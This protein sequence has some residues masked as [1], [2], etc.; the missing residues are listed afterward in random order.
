MLERLALMEAGWRYG[1]PMADALD[2]K[3]RAPDTKAKVSVARCTDYWYVA[4][5]SKD[6][7]SEPQAVTI[8]GIPMVLFRAEDGTPGALLDRCPHRNVPLSM[9]EVD[10]QIL[11]CAYHGWEF[12][13]GGKC[14][15]IPGL[16]TDSDS[17]GRDATSYPVREQQGYVWVFTNADKAPEVEPFDIPLLRDERYTHVRQLVE[18]PGTLHATIENALDVPHTAFLH[19]GLFRGKGERNDIQ[20]VIRR[21]SDRVEAQYIGEPRPEGL[22][23]RVA[24]PGGGEVEHYDRFFLPSVA[25]VEYKIGDDSHILVTSM[26]TPVED[27]HTKLFTVI[28][29]RFSKMPGWLVRPI[30]EPI[31]KKIFKQDAVML[32]K[33]TELIARFGG[34]QFVSTEIDLLGPQIWRLMKAAERGDA[35]PN[36]DDPV[37]KHVEMNV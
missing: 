1:A 22:A 6:L 36:E 8:L 35:A 14:K 7:R 15:L 19:K 17:D 20:V 12:G 5:A 34:E 24:S 21:W 9:G 10:G 4:C 18:A 28:S 2:P 30:L 31:G 27:F 29:F 37:V 33:Q 32:G 11:R 26:C 3:L 25:Q 13:T 16:K 23:A